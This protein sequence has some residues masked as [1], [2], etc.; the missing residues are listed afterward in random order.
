LFSGIVEEMGVVESFDGKR[1]SVRANECSKE[2]ALSESVCVSGACLTIVNLRDQII[3]FDI[4]PETLARTN[5][6]DVKQ[7][8]SL[9]LE[10]ALEVGQRNGGHFVQGHVD[11]TGILIS[12]EQRGNSFEMEISAPP[13]LMKY[14][15]DKGF[16]SVDGISL[17]IVSC[18]EE[19][20][21]ISLVPFTFVNTTMGDRKKGDLVNL[22]VDVIAKYIERL[23]VPY[24]KK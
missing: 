20:F 16:I 13:N 11:G 18:R 7:G 9:N 12:N 4:V 23:A 10:R 17:T 3:D 22:E 21:H 19:S 8:H 15:V 6:A 14:I 24:V 5:F 2:V 1:L